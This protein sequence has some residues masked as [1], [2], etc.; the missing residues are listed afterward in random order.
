M[1]QAGLHEKV[2]AEY[3][4]YHKWLDVAADLGITM[5]TLT[6]LRKD[7]GKSFGPSLREA[8]LHYCGLDAAAGIPP[9]KG[10][11]CLTEEDYA[12]LNAWAA[13]VNSVS[14]SEAFRRES[15]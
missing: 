4:I 14:G 15:L 8:V 2:M 1:I 12:Q 13:Y 9:H 6:T 7:E 10:F 11:E 5:G 3:D